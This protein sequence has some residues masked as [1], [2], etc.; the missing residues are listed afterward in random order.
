M[1]PS[2]LG[3]FVTANTGDFT[4]QY[5]QF[6]AI[7]SILFIMFSGFNF[8]TRLCSF[9]LPYSQILYNN[10]PFLPS[11]LDCR[12]CLSAQDAKSL[13]VS[14]SRSK[15]CKDSISYLYAEQPVLRNSQVNSFC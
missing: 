8:M 3:F 14:L 15:A 12:Y 6:S 13:D 7:T 4:I 9:W 1:A 2:A 10:Y 5:A 11:M